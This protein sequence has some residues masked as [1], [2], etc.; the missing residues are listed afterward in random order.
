MS[1]V[2]IV[3]RSARAARGRRRSRFGDEARR[4]GPERRRRGRGSV[5]E[6]TSTTRTATAG[7][8]VVARARSRLRRG[9]RCRR[10]RRRA[11]VP[12]RDRTPPRRCRL[13][14]HLET[15]AA[16]HPGSEVAEGGVVIDDEAPKRHRRCSHA[17]GPAEGRASRKRCPASGMAPRARRRE[18][19]DEK[20]PRRS[21]NVNTITVGQEN[22]API[23]L[24][25]RGPRQR[26]RRRAAARLAVGQP[27]LG[28]A[29]PPAARR[30]VPG[31][32]LRPRGF[33][34]S[35]RP[36]ERLRLRHARRRSRHGAD[37]AR[38]ARR[39]RSS[40]SRSAPASW[41]ATSARTG[42]S[43]SAAACSSRA[44]RRRS[45]SPRTTRKA[46][47]RRRRRRAAGDPR[48][49]LR[50]AHRAD[51]R[52]PQPRRL[53]RHPRQRGHRAGDVERRRRGVA[54]ATWACPPGWLEDFSQDI[55]R[56]DVPTLIIHGTAD[57]ILSIDGQGRRLHAAL[58]AARY[59]EIEGGPHVI[60]VTHAD[61]VNREL[62]RSCAS[63]PGSLPRSAMFDGFGERELADTSP[64]DDLRPRRRRRAAAPAAARLPADPPHVARRGGAAG[65]ST[66]PSS[67]STSPATA[68]VPAGARADHAPHS[69]RAIAATW[70]S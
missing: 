16:E 31:D 6:E 1:I 52:L 70:S 21:V 26:R 67:S 56:I 45:P 39:R 68:V 25:V 36:T 54:V 35:S 5:S 69:K 66:T 65:A 34:R 49:P 44:S 59:V 23:E 63:P 27:V 41:R 38:P 47:T 20:E 53:P 40:A 22:S 10:A 48:R 32:H 18:A 60:C 57:R 9:G 58:P 24:Y 17:A 15:P 13:A 29:A 28:A 30:R 62:L 61:E 33:G 8:A 7:R 11:A 2:V 3:P 19:G 4:A 64:G 37:R 14:D 12:R 55:E 51:G 43:G 42:P 50:L 46:S